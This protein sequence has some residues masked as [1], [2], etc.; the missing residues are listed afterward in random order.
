[1]ISHQIGD[2]GPA[3]GIVF[4]D[5]GDDT[6]GWRYLEAAPAEEEFQADWGADAINV[7]GTQIGVSTGKDNTYVIVAYL[8]SNDEYSAAAFKCEYFALN[9]YSDWFLPSK[10]ELDLMYKNLKVNGLGGFGAGYYW[11]SS[12]HN[13]IDAWSQYFDDGSQHNI[14]KNN[15]VNVRPVRAF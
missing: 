13:I 12:Q 1:M 4:Y 6:D 7:T 3:G 8:V 5:K 10:D 9:G 14:G 15:P 2:T 11:S